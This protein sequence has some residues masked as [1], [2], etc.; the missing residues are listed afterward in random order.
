MLHIAPFLAKILRDQTAMAVVRLFFEAQKTPA[1][2]QLA[3]SNFFDPA[4][5]YQI[6]ELLLIM[7]PVAFQPNEHAA[8]ARSKGSETASQSPA[9]VEQTIVFCDL[10]A[11]EQPPNG[12]VSGEFLVSFENILR[13]REFRDLTEHS[14]PI[15]LR[16]I[17][18]ALR[19]A[20]PGYHPHASCCP[21]RP[22]LNV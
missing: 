20:G 2:K 9:P 11:A 18:P 19:R 10:P 22:S 16:R 8:T 6:A 7:P 1:V 5:R 4:L 14:L 17:L 13:R 15:G 12:A 21:P 3:R